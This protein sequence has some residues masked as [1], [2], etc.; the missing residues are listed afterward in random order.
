MSWVYPNRFIMKPM[1]NIALV[2]CANQPDYKKCL[3]P[4]QEDGSP[5]EVYDYDG[6]LKKSLPLVYRPN[7]NQSFPAAE[8]R[9]ERS[10]FF[11]PT[12][13]KG[14]LLVDGRGP[15]ISKEQCRNMGGKT[16]QYPKNYNNSDSCY[17][18]NHGKGIIKFRCPD[19]L[20][21]P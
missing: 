2:D 4:L 5:Y 7:F 1:A 10:P 16:C 19:G 20:K 11:K 12:C 15:C 6:E 9:F 13:P 3:E 18:D 21:N 17:L 8:G 14:Q